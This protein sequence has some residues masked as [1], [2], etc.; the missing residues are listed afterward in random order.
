MYRGD[1]VLWRSHQSRNMRKRLPAVCTVTGSLMNLQIPLKKNSLEN[2]RKR[3]FSCLKFFGS[4]LPLSPIS[5]VE[6]ISSFFNEE[7]FINHHKPKHDALVPVV[8]LN[9]WF[10]SLSRILH[11][12]TLHRCIFLSFISK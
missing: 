7:T 4:L 9:R 12:F 5:L 8:P 3:R 6:R 11:I 2:S 10:S 1:I